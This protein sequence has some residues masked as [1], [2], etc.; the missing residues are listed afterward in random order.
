MGRGRRTARRRGGTKV[1]RKVR[2]DWK[3]KYRK[4]TFG[5]EAVRQAWDPSK[6]MKQNY[7]SMGLVSNPNYLKHAHERT[8]PT[9]NTDAGLKA[10]GPATNPVTFMDASTVPSLRDQLSANLPGESH[11]GEHFM[12]EL[13]IVYLEPLIRRHGDNYR[14][15]A[16]DL[17]LNFKQHSAKKL[18]RRCE[19]LLLLRA[20]QAS[21][22]D[23][24]AARSEADGKDQGEGEGEDESGS[25]SGNGDTN[26]DVHNKSSHGAG[27][28]ASA[29]TRSAGTS[30]ELGK[31]T[32]AV[33][34]E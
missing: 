10:T 26:M 14:K 28:R 15:M 21:E 27:A 20:K 7:E 4:T 23:K 16:R 18:Q 30:N 9:E 31:L 32:G 1:S 29:Q 12:T 19:R 24:D 13:E 25:D 8:E 22:N 6:T 17:K 34:F 33:V 2:N 11:R 5:H 3:Q